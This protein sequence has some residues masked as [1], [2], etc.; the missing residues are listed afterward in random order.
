MAHRCLLLPDARFSGITAISSEYLR[1]HGIRA[2]V[3]DIDNTLALH[4]DPALPPDIAA[5]LAAR[6]AEGILL[7]VS[8]NNAEERVA[9][10]AR[11]I[12]VQWV[13]KAHKPAPEGCRRA[14]ALFGVPKQQMA[15]IGDQLFT[16]ILGAR[17]FGIRALLVRP[18]APDHIWYIRLKRVLEKPLLWYY[19]KKGGPFYE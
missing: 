1:S 5:W 14:Q 18:L 9:P 12:G 10:F 4:D 3:L 6:K 15:L 11:R 17:L 19:E 13:S 8:S 16:D 7:A 2:L